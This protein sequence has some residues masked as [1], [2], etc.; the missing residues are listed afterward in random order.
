MAGEA[1]VRYST[2]AIFFHWTIAILLIGQVAGGL[3]MVNIPDEEASLKLQVFQLHKSFGV[4]ILLLSALRLLWRLINPAPPLPETMAGWEKFAA[5][6]SHGLFYFMLFA[7]PLV[8]WA[9]VSASPLNLPTVLFGVVPWPHMPFFEG[10]ADRQA[11]EDALA[12]VHEYLAFTT[13]GLLVLHIA[14]ALKHHFLDRDDVLARM[15]PLV[16]PKG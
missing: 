15:L 16:K 2:V 9:V 4:T 3:F 6:A 14:A 5:R 7:I 13:V 12:E 10:V 1:R 11:L 8:G